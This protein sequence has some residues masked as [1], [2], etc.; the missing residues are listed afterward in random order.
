MVK[1]EV[2]KDY[3]YSNMGG[4]DGIIR[5]IARTKCFVEFYNY[6]FAEIKRA[7]IKPFEDMFESISWDY[8]CCCACDL[9]K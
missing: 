1:F 3:N 2:G 8:N 7:K 4:R 6:K 5:I 9:R